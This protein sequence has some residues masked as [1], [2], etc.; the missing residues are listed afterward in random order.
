MIVELMKICR[1]ALEMNDGSHFENRF[2]YVH[3]AFFK[4]EIDFLI[5]R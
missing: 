4:L 1:C 2:I 3:S 5:M